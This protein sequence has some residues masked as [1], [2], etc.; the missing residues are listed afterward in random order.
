MKLKAMK[1]PCPKC[2]SEA[3]VVATLSVQ[4]NVQDLRGW[5]CKNCGFNEELKHE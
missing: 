5:Q 1:R 3:D 4:G 2:N